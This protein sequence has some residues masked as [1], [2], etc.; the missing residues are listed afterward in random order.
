ML[1]ILQGKSELSI[2]KRADTWYYKNTERETTKHKHR[3][4]RTKEMTDFRLYPAD[5]YL[6][7]L[8]SRPKKD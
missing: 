2:E 7:R 6:E 1:F 5:R 3:Q 4:R 8:K